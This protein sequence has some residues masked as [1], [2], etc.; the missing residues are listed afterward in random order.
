[1]KIVYPVNIRFPSERANSIQIINTCNALAEKGVKVYLLLR[2]GYRKNLNDSLAFYNLKKNKKLIIPR[3]LVLNTF[4]FKSS[5]PSKLSFFLSSFVYTL[6]L[7]LKKEVDIIYTREFWQVRIFSR[8]RFIHK[9]PIIYECHFIDYLRLSSNADDENIN[10]KSLR[11]IRK[12]EKILFK[13]VDGL[14]VITQIL[15]NLIAKEYNRKKNVAIIPD[16]TQLFN[17][18]QTFKTRQKLK[19]TK[20]IYVGQLYQWKGVSTLIEA[21]LFLKDVRLD[22]FGG[23]SFE[24]DLGAI[25]DLSKELDVKKKITFHGFQPQATVQKFLL[26]ADIAVI[27]LPDNYIAANFTSP[28]KLFEYMA[29]GLP[30]VASNLPSLKEILKNEE[31]A[32]LV[33]PDSPEALAEGIKRLIDDNELRIKIANQARKDIESYSW[34]ERANRIIDFCTKLIEEKA[35]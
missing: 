18:E 24:S 15:K 28:L 35:T 13:N 7:I 22:I 33:R 27:P 9:K 31:N 11:V 1:M 8:L 12:K 20:L 10:K 29:A 32:I 21:L 3:L 19:T 23:L 14:V 5:M 30:I 34:P 4:G 17:L 26:N 16:G 6:F 2:R 25:I